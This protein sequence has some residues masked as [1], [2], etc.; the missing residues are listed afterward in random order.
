M[1]DLEHLLHEEGLS[2]LGLFSLRRRL[3]E[4]LINVFKYLK[5]GER[6]INV[7]QALLGGV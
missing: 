5:G 6:Q 7:G 3:R 1:K 4:N 2:N